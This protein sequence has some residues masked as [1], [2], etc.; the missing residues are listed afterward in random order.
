LTKASY[1]GTQGLQSPLSS[2]ALLRFGSTLQ[3]KSSWVMLLQP[4]LAAVLSIS[5]W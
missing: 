1:I 3:Q 4:M 5:C 2:K